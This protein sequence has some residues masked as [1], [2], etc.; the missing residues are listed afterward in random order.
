MLQFYRIYYSIYHNDELMK[1]DYTGKMLRDE[2]CVKDEDYTLTW[3][4]IESCYYREGTN[5]NF[6][7]YTFKKGRV[8]SFF[9][10]SVIKC[11][12]NKNWRDIVEWKTP[13]INI[14][15]KIQYKP[16]TPSLKEVMEYSDSDAA[17]QYLNEHGL[18]I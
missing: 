11:I 3:D 6:A 18:K 16:F 5:Y 1:K 14:K 4:N 12:K 15:I 9:D 7:L 10:N 17:I 13:D 8:I 2:N